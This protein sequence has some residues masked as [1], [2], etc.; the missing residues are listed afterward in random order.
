MRV[1]MHTLS[2]RVNLQEQGSAEPNIVH[3]YINRQPPQ[4]LKLDPLG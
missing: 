4:P 3:N 1:Y 2:K